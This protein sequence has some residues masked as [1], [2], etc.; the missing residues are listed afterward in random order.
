MIQPYDTQEDR[1]HTREHLIRTLTICRYNYVSVVSEVVESNVDKIFFDGIVE[2]L[3]I[4]IDKVEDSLKV[5]SFGGTLGVMFN[6]IKLFAKLDTLIPIIVRSFLKRGDFTWDKIPEDSDMI[7]DRLYSKTLASFMILMVCL[8]SEKT[9]ICKAYKD[10]LLYH[11]CKIKLDPPPEVMEPLVG[12]YLS[13]NIELQIH[14]YIKNYI[15]IFADVVS[16]DDVEK[17]YIH[18]FKHKDQFIHDGANITNLVLFHNILHI[19][20]PGILD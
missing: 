15:M 20:I 11:F 9:D 18:L 10:G 6:S 3:N 14:K 4:C 19:E 16:E 13:Y 1:R 12:D 8:R 7:N 2:T 17:V 5:S